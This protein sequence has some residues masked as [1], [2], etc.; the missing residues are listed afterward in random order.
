MAGVGV[1]VE[2]E[3]GGGRRACVGTDVALN[4]RA[5]GRALGCDAVAEHSA[6]GTVCEVENSGS[7]F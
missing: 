3:G 6:T 4:V 5:A 1:G 7:L 2:G